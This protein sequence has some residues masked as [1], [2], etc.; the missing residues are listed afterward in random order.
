VVFCNGKYRVVTEAAFEKLLAADDALRAR[1]GLDE[2]PTP[3]AVGSAGS[4][5]G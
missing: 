4:T 2:L 1:L 5:H 3:G